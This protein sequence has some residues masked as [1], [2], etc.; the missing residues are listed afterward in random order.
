MWH[1]YKN[2]KFRMQNA[3]L[4]RELWECKIK[5]KGRE[6]LVLFHA[7]VYFILLISLFV[8][9]AADS[10]VINAALCTFGK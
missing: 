7:K 1:I 10:Y 5:T 9:N 2:A 6:F 3:K 4:E 8:L